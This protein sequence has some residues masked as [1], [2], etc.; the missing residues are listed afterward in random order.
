ME[1]FLVD[2]SRKIFKASI[3]HEIFQNLNISLSAKEK[4]INEGPEKQM[5]P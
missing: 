4:D 2:G 5:N 1:S 3:S